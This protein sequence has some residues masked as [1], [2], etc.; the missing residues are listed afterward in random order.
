M[1]MMASTKQSDDSSSS[2]DDDIQ[3]IRMTPAILTGLFISFLLIC[4]SSCGITGLM[5]LQSP[6]SFEREGG[7]LAGQ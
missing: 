6:D 2:G 7:Y 1:S 4:I 3:Y 5:A